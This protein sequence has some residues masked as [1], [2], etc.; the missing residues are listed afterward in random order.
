MIF[1]AGLC[2]SAFAV[3]LLTAASLALAQGE[4][5]SQALNAGHGI[6][7]FLYLKSWSPYAAGVGIGILSWF[8]FLLS[9]H[10]LGV[11]TAYARSS[12]M[13]ETAIRGEKARRR[14]Y[15]QKFAPE[16]DWEWML[17]IGLIAGAALSAILSGD[18]AWRFVPGA[19]ASHFGDGWLLRW[20]TA[21]I[22]GA[23]MGVGARWANGCT[24]GHALSGT[25]QLVLSSWVAAI[26]IFVGGIIT[27]LLIF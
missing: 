8:A 25:M 22:G 14:P 1:R 6:F 3:L 7:G 2:V 13:I 24:S 10:P 15:Y 11:S 4:V 5:E 23:I 26:G 21:F 27:A 20:S 17:V 18:F 16:I 12:G 19:W 9:D